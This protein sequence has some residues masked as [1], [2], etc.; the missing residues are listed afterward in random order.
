MD[1][2][3]RSEIEWIEGR[4]QKGGLSNDK[5]NIKFECYKFPLVASSQGEYGDKF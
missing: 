4:N 3:K 2:W 5:M 1:W